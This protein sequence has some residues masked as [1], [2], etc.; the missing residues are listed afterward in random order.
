MESHSASQQFTTS[1]YPMD[2]PPEI[3][4][5]IFILSLPSLDRAQVSQKVALARVCRLWNDIIQ[6]S[7]TLW[8]G[9]SIM[10]QIGYVRKSLLK[11]GQS[12]IDIYGACVYSSGCRSG[13]TCCQFIREVNRHAQRWRHVTLHVM[14]DSGYAPSCNLFPLLKSLKLCS[15]PG[16]PTG[17]EYLA[18]LNSTRT[19]YLR[20]LSLVQPQIA[21]SNISLSPNLSKLTIIS[22]LLSSS[23]LLS[24]LKDCPNLSTLH[25]GRFRA[26]DELV[27]RADDASMVELTALQRLDLRHTPV[28]FARNLLQGLRLP[29]DCTMALELRLDDATVPMSFWDNP[30]SLYHERSQSASQIDQITITASAGGRGGA[31]IVVGG[32]RRSVN[33]W[34]DSLRHVKDALEWLGIDTESNNGASQFE[35]SF[36]DLVAP[37]NRPIGTLDFFNHYDQCLDLKNLAPILSLQCITR[38]KTTSIQCRPPLKA[39]ISYISKPEPVTTGSPLGPEHDGAKNHRTKAWSLPNLRE[40]AMEVPMYDEEW[41]RAIEVVKGRSGQRI[42]EEPARL[43]R[44]EFTYKSDDARTIYEDPREYSLHFTDSE[45]KRLSQLVEVMDDDAEFFWRGLRISG[46]GEVDKRVTGIIVEGVCVWPS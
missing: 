26:N 7:P 44:I 12:P 16:L 43:K 27:S 3:W 1:R 33:L 40:L 34:L 18:L 35:P 41:K 46:N 29:E 14:F 42:L 8:A 37:K 9:V 11:S 5:E 20:E 39:L 38:I 28:G 2:M 24:I 45:W 36:M 30:L 31:Q 15:S 32:C 21:H 25:L 4:I 6:S 22:S 19:P 23:E 10:D 17:E 13:G